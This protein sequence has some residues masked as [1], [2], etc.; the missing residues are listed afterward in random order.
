MGENNY[1]SESR[2]GSRVSWEP[3]EN[4]KKIN[5]MKW[6]RVLAVVIDT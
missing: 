2:G 5:I 3:F 6:K 1:G 4:R